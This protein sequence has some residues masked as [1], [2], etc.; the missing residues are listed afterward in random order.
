MHCTA[1]YALGLLFIFCVA[2]I[3]ALSSVLV[4]YLYTGQ[5]F[6]SPFLLTYTGVSLF[7]LW[8]PF[9]ACVKAVQKC[10][11]QDEEV[12]VMRH[13]GILYHDLQMNEESARGDLSLTGNVTSQPA[14]HATAVLDP[15]APWTHR[16]HFRVAL[17]I[18]PVWFIG[19]SALCSI[20][21]D[22]PVCVV[23]VCIACMSLQQP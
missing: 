19:E 21:A 12:I 9:R 6:H 8:L 11:Q 1:S 10:S 22:T 4:Q 3:W 5:D 17:Q 2:V 7:A 15:Y 16:Q 23:L 20:V 14:V 13:S 18:A